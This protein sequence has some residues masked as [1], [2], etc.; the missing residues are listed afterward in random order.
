[1]QNDSSACLQFLIISP[2]PY[3]YF[4]HL[5]VN[6]VFVEFPRFLFSFSFFFFLFSFLLLCFFFAIS[7]TL[8][9][10]L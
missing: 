10:K 9:F 7:V 3:F 2:D 5:L 6:L 8:L 1:M 4:I